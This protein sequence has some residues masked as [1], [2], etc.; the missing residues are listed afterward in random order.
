MNVT[1]GK[2][3]NLSKNFQWQKAETKGII[4]VV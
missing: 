4:S 2:N 1:T 3:N